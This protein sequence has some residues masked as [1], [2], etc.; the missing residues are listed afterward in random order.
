MT[1]RSAWSSEQ[2]AVPSSGALYDATSAPPTNIPG[3]PQSQP[4]G[5]GPRANESAWWSANATSDPWRD[6]SA[7]AAVVIPAPEAPPVAEPDFT[8]KPRSTSLVQVVMISLLAAILAG[9]LGGALG[10]LA[11]VR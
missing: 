7:A 6:P 9:G 11:A 4:L 10:Y 2:W 1:E 8:P 3:A 5:P